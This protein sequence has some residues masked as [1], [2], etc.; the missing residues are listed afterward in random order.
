MGN[1]EVSLGAPEGRTHGERKGHGGGVEKREKV[2]RTMGKGP[3]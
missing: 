2:K 1:G 3:Q